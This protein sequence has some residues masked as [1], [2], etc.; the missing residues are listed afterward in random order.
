MYAA[1]NPNKIVALTIDGS[2]GT[3]SAMAGSPFTA[4]NMPQFVAIDLS[5]KFLYVTDQ[6]S[7]NASAYSIA[8]STG[9]LTPITGSPFITES[10]PRGVTV[11]HTQERAL[12]C[13]D[14]VGAAA[15]GWPNG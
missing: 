9:V 13:G 1:V 5:G 14:S 15:R 3:L 7:D 8:S 11:V 6:G 12:H 2:T 4:G 10:V